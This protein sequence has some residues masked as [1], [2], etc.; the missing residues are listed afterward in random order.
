VIL[1]IAKLIFSVP[2]LLALFSRIQDAIDEYRR[3]AQRR[4]I[5][6]DIDNWVRDGKDKQSP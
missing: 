5:G 4:R 3:E 6:D 2:Q 1:Q